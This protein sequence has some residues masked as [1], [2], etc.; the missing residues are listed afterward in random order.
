MPENISI[1][2][3]IQRIDF[4]GQ[5]REAPVY[6]IN[7]AHCGIRS[8]LFFLQYITENLTEPLRHSSLYKGFHPTVR[9]GKDYAKVG[10][11]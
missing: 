6:G 4:T 11:G 2:H 5:Q 1:A 9:I 10:I 3:R 8:F 7:V